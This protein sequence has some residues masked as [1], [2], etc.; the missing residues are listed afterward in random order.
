MKLGSDS[1][2]LPPT[3]NHDACALL[4]EALV[5]GRGQAF[6]LNAA[7]VHR[8]GARAAQLIA[9][10]VRS[11]QADGFEF[12]V[13]APSPGFLGSLGRLGLTDAILERGSAHVG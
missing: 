3:L 1:Y 7:R 8:L 4:A 5:G 10:A 6:T 2:E 9:V 12:H 13:E 11:W